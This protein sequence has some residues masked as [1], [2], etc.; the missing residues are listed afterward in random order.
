MANPSNLNR[1]RLLIGAALASG[2]AGA[3]IAWWREQR[4]AALEDLP[5]GTSDAQVLQAFWALELATPSGKKLALSS[6]K[7]K[8]LLI[9][10][11]ATWCPPCVEELPLIDSFY[12]KNLKNGWQVLGLAVDQFAAVNSFL[13]K[14]PL[15]FPVA[16]AGLAGIEMSKSLG[17]LSGGLPFTVVLSASG[18]IAQRKIGRITLED[19]TAW[20]TIS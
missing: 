1:R 5:S 14:M 12:Q 16:L 7:G 11:W 15:S 18:N 3:G 2:L 9:N 6:F 20:S 8:P 10:F 19:L 4:P 13:G 17:N